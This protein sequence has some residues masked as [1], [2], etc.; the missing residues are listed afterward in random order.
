[1][2]S[3]GKVGAIDPA[4]RV[5]GRALY[6]AIYWPAERFLR[7]AFHSWIRS[8]TFGLLMLPAT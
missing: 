7:R 6:S 4:D 1:M 5:P 3:E 2:F 8:T